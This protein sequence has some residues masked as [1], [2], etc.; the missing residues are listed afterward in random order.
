MKS[1]ESIYDDLGYPYIEEEAVWLDLK[2][3]LKHPR[4]RFKKVDRNR[5]E[6]EYYKPAFAVLI[7][8]AC[9]LLTRNE[10]WSTDCY[11]D[12]KVYDDCVHIRLS[13]NDNNP[14]VDYYFTD[15]YPA[16]LYKKEV[17]AHRKD[18][19]AKG[20]YDE[21]IHRVDDLPFAK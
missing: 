14:F 9:Q 21:E 8:R 10:G 4:I 20:V 12:I 13:D 18:L 17:L 6:R 16:T 1:F 5:I 15:K 3:F 7:I 2:S 19:I 11:A